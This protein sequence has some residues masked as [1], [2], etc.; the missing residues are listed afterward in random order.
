MSFPKVGNNAPAFALL[1]QAGE[2]VALKDFRGE[3][4]V[5]VYFYPKAMTPGCT[6]QACG[7]RDTAAELEKRD[8]VVLGISPDPVK[9][10]AKFAER[11]A[12]NFTLLA[13]E[14][15]AVA[16]KYGAW[17]PKK[18]MGREFDGILRTTFIV[19]KEGKLAAV[20]D[21]FKTKTHHDDLIAALDG[22]GLG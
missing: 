18:F 9:R 3:K 14:D 13:D 20:L 5:A 15:H 21:K 17:G 19:N 7:L 8:T 2:K 1:N 6:V 16:D 11:D 10:L 22:L 4:N 12:L